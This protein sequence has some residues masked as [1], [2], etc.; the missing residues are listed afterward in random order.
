MKSPLLTKTPAV[1]IVNCKGMSVSIV[2][3]IK[4]FLEYKENSQIKGVI[5]NQMPAML[6]PRVK[7]LIESE[8]EIQVLGYV[9]KVEDCVI[10][11]GT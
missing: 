10:E 5:L 4:G 8:L 1:L 11:A 9:P 3:Y 7:Q 2:P 6:Y